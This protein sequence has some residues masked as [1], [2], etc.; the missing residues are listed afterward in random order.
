MVDVVVAILVLSVPVAALIYAALSD[1]ITM[2]IP[3]RISLGL[4]VAFLL[5]A[6]LAGMGAV[7]LGF[8]A[9]AALLVFIACFAL[10]A[11]NVMGGG[12]A[13]LLTAIALWYGLNSSLIA[14]LTA[15][16][17]AG[18]VVTLVFLLLRSQAHRVVSLG[19]PLPSS[20]VTAKKIPYGIAIAIGGMLTLGQSPLYMWALRLF[21]ES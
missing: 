10:F 20:M 15:V 13:K 21:S 8:A 17:F 16:A 3:N 5:L 7:E 2:T 6:P 14:F 18:G 11:V 9:L 1:L 4:A 19:V 12:D